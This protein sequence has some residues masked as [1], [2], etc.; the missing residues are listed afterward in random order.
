VAALVGLEA[1]LGIGNE[2]SAPGLENENWGTAH[3]LSRRM[4]IAAQVAPM[5][6]CFSSVERCWARTAA[7]R[8][9]SA[10]Y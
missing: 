6:R 10:G 5:Y 8:S 1:E 2:Q 9:N 3:W 7:S 4:E